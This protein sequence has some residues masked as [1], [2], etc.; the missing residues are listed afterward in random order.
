MWNVNKKHLIISILFVI[1]I[2]EFT[3]SF[4]DKTPPLS[5]YSLYL[6]R[7]ID[8]LFILFGLFYNFLININIIKKIFKIIINY[9]TPIIITLIILDISLSLAGFGYPTN[10]EEEKLE[11]SPHPTD[12]FR[13]KPNVRDH[14]EFGFRGDFINSQDS[15]NVAFFGGSTGYNGDPTII[16]IVKQN[17]LSKKIKINVFN[18][19][20]V[21]SSHSQHTHR[22]LEFSDQINLDL[23]IFYGGGNE[24]IQYL[25]FDPRPGYPYNFYFRNELNPLKQVLIR[26]SSI[27]GIIEYYSGGIISGLK[28][29]KN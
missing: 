6:V 29:I 2:N 27:I 15:F 24:T 13:G 10:Y 18:F 23:V 28:K 25:N 9:L 4:F 1:L 21:A 20:S 16:E 17:L 22:L 8:I 14:N 3:V 5:D 7:T 11:R 19:S 12:V 26:Y